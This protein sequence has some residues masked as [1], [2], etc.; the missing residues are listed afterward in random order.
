MALFRRPPETPVGPDLPQRVADSACRRVAVLALH[1]GAGAGTVLAALASGLQAAGLQPGLTS[2]AGGPVEDDPAVWPGERTRLPAGVVAATDPG[3]LEEGGARVTVL[4]PP[5]DGEGGCALVRVE[6]EG[7]IVLHGPEDGA[8][9]GRV[10]ERLERVVSGPLCVSGR[11]ERRSFAAPG[12]VDGWVLAVGAAFSPTPER[13]AAAVRH[14]VELARRP[15]CDE[16]VRLAWE[17]AM[18]RND[19]VLV[20]GGGAVLESIP[21]FA[22][23]LSDAIERVDQDR[24]H[25]IVFPGTI[26]DD[27]VQPLVRGRWRGVLV[28]RDA[29]RIH[30]AP[31]YYRAWVK[32]GGSFQV[33]L[34]G[35][36]IAIATNPV[37]PVGEDA[38]AQEFRDRVAEAV[39]DVPVHDVV[40]DAGGSGK[41]AGWRLWPR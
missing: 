37:S 26:H 41:P 38:D 1:P 25:A 40:L 9:M 36:L 4:E 5:V 15:P 7:P 14:H 13:A 33:V 2:A 34:P 11:W 21:A 28:A 32:E 39:P 22:S 20:G 35:R 6:E 10:M 8:K 12:Q 31:V 23:E 29:T 19:V 17:V 3:S 18:S 24:L 16:L 30:A 27:L